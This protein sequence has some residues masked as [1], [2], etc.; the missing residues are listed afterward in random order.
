MWVAVVEGYAGEDLLFE[1]LFETRPYS[2]Y[3]HPVVNL[4][5]TI[6]VQLG[7]VL[8]KIAQVVCILTTN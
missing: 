6:Q 5:D 7:I 2:K 3:S 4:S 1:E 8:L